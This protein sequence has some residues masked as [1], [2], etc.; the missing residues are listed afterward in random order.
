MKIVIRGAVQG[1]GMRPFIARLARDLGISGWVLNSEEGVFVEAEGAEEALSRFLRRIQSDPP[2]A[3][4]IQ[5]LEFSWHDPV[6]YDGFEIRESVKSARPTVL[7]LPDIAVCEEC[8][9]DTFV[10]SS[11]RYLYPFTNCTNCGPR[12]SII[13]SLPYDRPNT[14]MKGFRMCPLC[15]AEYEDPEDRRYHAQ[16]NACPRC[17]PS[18]WMVLDHDPIVIR[19]GDALIVAAYLL[20]QGKILAIKG[21]GGFHL[22]CDARNREAVRTLRERKRRYEKPLAV[23]FPSLEE[24]KK[25]CFVSREE[26]S[27]L[28]SPEAPIVL[29]RERPDSDIAPEV[30]PGN[31]YL[32]CFLPYTP[33]HHILMTSAQFPC[34]ATSGNLSDEPMATNN[35]EALE[36]LGDIADAFVL[37]DRP[38]ARRVDDSVMFL[39]NKTR[40]LIRRARGFAPLPIMVRRDLPRV[41]ALGGHHKNT[42]AISL[43]RNVFISQHIGDLDTPEALSAFRETVYDMMRLWEFEPEVVAVDMHPDYPSTRFGE[44]MGLP[45][46]RVQHHHAHLASVA[47]EHDVDEPVLGFCWDGT[48]WGT[49][50]TVWGGEFIFGDWKDYQRLA[51]FRPFRLL[52]GE[53]AVREPARCGLSL[54]LETFGEAAFDLNLPPVEHFSSKELEVLIR[55][56]E[57]G[58]RS[59]LTSAVGRLFDGV[60]SIL[61]IR[62]KVSFESQAAMELEFCSRGSR[63]NY[64]YEITRE[65]DLLE[66]DWRPMIRE[67]VQDLVKGKSK[68][69]IAMRFHM[70]LIRAGLEVTKILGHDRV[71]VSG[72]CWQNRLL[73]GFLVEEA[74]GIRVY[75]HQRVPPNDGGLCLGQALVAGA[76]HPELTLTQNFP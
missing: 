70:T 11:R 32:G 63:R 75:W 39:F 57:T 40:V 48:G 59:P 10:P 76:R 38:I 56:H 69:A 8:L 33:L 12:F 28:L 45:L 73:L 16:P 49:D 36:K 71:F 65:G 34:V 62:Q 21:L 47:G 41:L 68:T 51:R 35:D 58:F 20:G 54:L 18:A 25:R 13:E 43:G 50:G 37:H 14:T 60:A 61:G 66:I 24:I 3:A 52:G 31:P 72:G 17:G 29:L 53:A 7:V 30:A 1:V 23:M 5:S 74:K 44:E 19:D 67:V 9:V 55:M 26:Q 4:R 2:P 42:I 46:I 15:R 64:E 27:A 22:F 6:G